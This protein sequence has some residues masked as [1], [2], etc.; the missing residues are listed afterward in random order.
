VAKIHYATNVVP[1]VHLMV[2]SN[3][4]LLSHEFEDKHVPANKRVYHQDAINERRMVNVNPQDLSAIKKRFIELFVRKQPPI[5]HSLPRDGA[6]SRMDCIIGISGRVMDILNYYE[7]RDYHGRYM[8][9]YCLGG[10]SKNLCNF[11]EDKRAHMRKRIMDLMD[12][13]RLDATERQQISTYMG[14]VGSP[15]TTTTTL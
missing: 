7:P 15:T 12:Q 6:F 14:E 1:Y 13:Y 2:T 5:A 3:Q 11:P 9:L 4:H 8:Y 10:L